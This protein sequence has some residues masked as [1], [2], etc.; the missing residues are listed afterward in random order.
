MVN[1]KSRRLSSLSN[2]G[3]TAHARLFARSTEDPVADFLRRDG[4]P[5]DFGLVIPGDGN[6]FALFRKVNQLGEPGLGSQT[7]TVIAIAM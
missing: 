7:V 5:L 3:R 6:L 2:G 4:S 1:T